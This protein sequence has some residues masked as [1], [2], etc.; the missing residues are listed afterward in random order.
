MIYEDGLATLIV[1]ECNVED[2]GNYI[3]KATNCEGRS[4][5]DF[6]VT[7]LGTIAMLFKFVFLKTLMWGS[8]TKYLCLFGVRK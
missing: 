8:L 3:L 2:H 1:K 5:I 6:N 4:Q 7:V